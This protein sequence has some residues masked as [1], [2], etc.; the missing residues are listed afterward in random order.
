MTAQRKNTS[1][2]SQI[3]LNKDIEAFIIEKDTNNE[4]YSKGDKEYINRYEGY[5]GQHSKGAKGE[6]VLYEYYTPDYICE[7]M[8]D[9]AHFH[10]CPKG[11]MLEPSCGTG[12]F[13]KQFPH[14]NKVTAFET[15]QTAKRIAEI[16]YPEATIYNQ[17]FETAFL[18][19][20]RL[21]TRIK[22][23]EAT[24]LE[25]Y[26]FS[27]VIGNPPFGKF[28]NLYSSYFRA[29]SFT[30]FE[31]FFMYYGLKLLK[32]GGLLLY[33][34]SNNFLRNGFSYNKQKETIG[35]LAGLV[36]AYRL[37]PVMKNTGVPMDIIILKRI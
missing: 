10:N 21:T 19:Y 34:T 28:R 20:P 1:R 7:L 24:W 31:M 23:K 16:N 4:S 32:P 26:P 33:F 27:L 30:Q 6:G 5:G 35:K 9:L 18:E 12:R 22:G 36:D 13:I 3:E 2:K 29:P 8:H 15:N 25:G 11:T 14:K 17:H 37:P